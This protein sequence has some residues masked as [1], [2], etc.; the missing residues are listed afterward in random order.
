MKAKLQAFARSI[1]FDLCKVAAC[2]PPPHADAFHQWIAEGRHGE[3]QWMERNSERR[4]DP[5]QVLQNARSVIVL[6]LNYWQGP[7]PS[8]ETAEAPAHGRIARYA[9]G[10]DY[11][12]LIE[13]RLRQIDQWLT[14]HGGSQRFYVDT[15]PVLERDFAALAGLGWHGKSTMLINRDFGTWFFLAEL[16]TTLDIPPDQ[17]VND[18][19]GKCTRC[20]DACPTGAIHA[21]HQLD[22][23]L[24]VSYLTIELK[25]SIPLELRPLIGD[26]VYGCDDCLSA[27]PWNRFAQV[28]QDVAFQARPFVHSMSL[29]D[30]LALD[31]TEFS[32]LFK[33]SPIKRIKRRGLLRNVCVALGNVGT[34][35]DLPA[36]EKAAADPEP[37]IA[38]HASWAID[39]IRRRLPNLPAQ[40]REGPEG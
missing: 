37:L 35:E 1:G 28:A 25:G 33:G 40:N 23:R 6:G 21:P 2:T 17:P 24:C 16:L 32:A 5:Q 13:P 4:T 9:W 8:T 39:S 18:H 26:R 22:A 11:H 15:G 19:C 3:M 12:D 29:R 31:Q 10:A 38:E 20:I 14:T 34:L 7:A 30:L 27:C 36:L